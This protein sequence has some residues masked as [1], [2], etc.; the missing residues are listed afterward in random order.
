M[1]CGFSSR[2][3]LWMHL[4]RSNSTL[5]I[6]FFGDNHQ[7]IN[8]SNEIKLRSGS[9]YSLVLVGCCAVHTEGHTGGEML[10]PLISHRTL[11]LFFTLYPFLLLHPPLGFVYSV[12]L[13]VTLPR[14]RASS[15]QFAL[16][17][18]HN[19]VSDNWRSIVR[20]VIVPGA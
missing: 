17:I 3:G 16:L 20:L 7:S 9:N 13:D 5:T 18:S 6:F 10:G 8:Q 15:M 4:R 14:T 19:S 11:V 2:G 12:L 1:L